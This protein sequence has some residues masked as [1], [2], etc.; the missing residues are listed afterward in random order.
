MMQHTDDI[1]LCL[2]TDAQELIAERDRWC[3]H[4]DAVDAEGNRVEAL[5]P[6]ARR[7]CAAGSMSRM[8]QSYRTMDADGYLMAAATLAINNSFDDRS[9]FDLAAANDLYGHPTIMLTYDIACTLRLHD[10][11]DPC[12]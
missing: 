11:E 12:P 5:D 10:L 8:K 4:A 2:I 1:V 3:Q 6:S 9:P 7:W